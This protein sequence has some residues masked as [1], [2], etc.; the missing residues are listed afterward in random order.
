MIVNPS[1][2]VTLLLPRC[3]SRDTLRIFGNAA[4]QK[5][6]VRIASIPARATLAG[7]QRRSIA[8]SPRRALKAMLTATAIIVQSTH[9][10][11][12]HANPNTGNVISTKGKRA[13]CTAHTIEADISSAIQNDRCICLTLIH[14]LLCS[15]FSR[16][17]A[18]TETLNRRYAE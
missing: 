17:P 18:W 16:S 10:E 4:I 15:L 11:S 6:A 12:S 1:R 14:I 7:K 13:Q 5:I 9:A 8:Y 3:S 2:D